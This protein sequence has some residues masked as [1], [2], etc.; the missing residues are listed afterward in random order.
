MF[1][2][3]LKKILQF[4]S[5]S[6]A[7]QDLVLNKYESFDEEKSESQDDAQV[8]RAIV[9]LLVPETTAETSR[10][11]VKFLPSCPVLL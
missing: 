4:I 3:Q 11:K 5:Q 10:T 1:W 6:S 8:E 2:F 9:V 7:S